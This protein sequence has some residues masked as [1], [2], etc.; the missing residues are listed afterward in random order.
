MPPA[1]YQKRPFSGCAIGGVLKKG[2][3]MNYIIAYLLVGFVHSAVMARFFEQVSEN[4]IFFNF[5]L[6]VVLIPLR[7]FVML[8][9]FMAGY[10]PSYY[11]RRYYIW[12]RL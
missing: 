6:W 2:K 7:F 9:R 4:E 10:K 11:K 3:S 1:L 12:S 8:W 5:A